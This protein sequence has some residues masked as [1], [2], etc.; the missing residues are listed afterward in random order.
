MV[1]TPS[2]DVPDFIVDHLRKLPPETLLAADEY[3]RGSTVV[4]PDEL[5]NEL[6][7]AFA[8]Q[9]ES[10]LEAIG[11][12]ATAV[13]DYVQEHDGESLA[14]VTEDENEDGTTSIWDRFY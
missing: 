5:P 8:L 2:D 10:T 12:Y 7:E 6:I 4:A 11:S 1:P 14:D 9:D 13:A 3:A